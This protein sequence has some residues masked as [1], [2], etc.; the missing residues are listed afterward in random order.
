MAQRPAMTLVLH[1]RM[2]AVRRRE[3]F[4][5]QLGGGGGGVAEAWVGEER[6]G[7][8]RGRRIGAGFFLSVA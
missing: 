8:C 3:E 6:D 4:C 2:R 1:A 7:A 5:V